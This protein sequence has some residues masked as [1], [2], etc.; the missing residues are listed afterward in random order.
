MN[1][2]E[3]QAKA[4]L[5]QYGVSVP[6]GITAHTPQEAVAAAKEMGSS[7]VVKAQVHS[8]GRGKAGGIRIANTLDE[9]EQ[10][11]KSLIGKRLITAQTDSEGIPVSALLI[12]EVLNIES[13]YYLAV[14]IDVD[15][16]APLVVASSAG[17]V[18]IEQVAQNT[19]EMISK[20]QGHPLIGIPP[21]KARILST[22][23]NSDIAIQRGIQSLIS[24]VCKMFK[25]K[26]CTLVEINPL[27]VTSDKRVLA[28]DAK[29]VIDDDALFRHPQLVKLRDTTQMNEL[30][31]KASLANLS[32][33]K[34]PKGRIGCM[35]NGAGLAMATMDI[36]KSVG[37][38]PA[39]FLD[40][41]GSTD[42]Q[43]IAE[44]Y[45][46]IV[47]DSSVEVIFIN[48]FAGIARADL[49]A[50]GILSASK[51]MSKTVPIVITMRGTNAQKG[52]ILLESSGLPVKYT[53]NLTEAS[54]AL[55]KILLTTN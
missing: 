8:G 2:H 23:L 6:Y 12:E 1:I 14:T 20:V 43:K 52:K 41:G 47:E 33:V 18:D 7:V 16:C 22:F 5:R 29:V 21:Y 48:L 26:D 55:Q 27:A 13:E 17:G 49:V 15:T 31:L 37:A 39:N 44:A 46:I 42:K 53:E 25:E 19:P 50:E 24:S 32:Y 30:E 54:Q 3:Y 28:A 34:L 9:V 40:V 36:I 11:A 35:V 51:Q 10:Y 4:L 38:E 45:K